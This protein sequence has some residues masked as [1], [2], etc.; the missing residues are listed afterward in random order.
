MQDF[1]IE[2]RTNLSYREF[3][4]TYLY[5]GKP[6]IISDALESW[7][8]MKKWNLDYFKDNFGDFEVTVQ[9]ELIT[10]GE[11]IDEV[12]ASSTENP[13]RY[14]NGLVIPKDLPALVDDILPEVKYTLPDRMRSNLLPFYKEPTPHGI[15]ELL[16]TGLGGKFK[17]HYDQY[18]LLGFV[19]Q[20]FGD[21]EFTIYGPEQ[22]Q[23]LYPNAVP[24]R[25]N[26]SDLTDID[27]V[28][29]D[30]FPLYEQA[31]P[32]KFVLHAGEMFF[33]PQG[34]WHTTRALTPSIATVIST[35]NEANWSEFTDDYCR[36]HYGRNTYKFY[37]DKLYYRVVGWYFSLWD[38]IN[39]PK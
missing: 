27:N 14:F 23:Y 3:A 8:A 26:F 21:K 17:L 35:V 28:D 20:V 32:Y 16:I 15:P 22:S 10:L 37:R 25:E 2:R 9:G 24:L 12:T 34:W 29:L 5:P 19:T 13:S 7:P 4:E 30:L 18:H 11:F 6:V 31:K 1:S 38:I 33:N 39:T 36:I